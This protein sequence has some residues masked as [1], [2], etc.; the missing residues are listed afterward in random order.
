MTRCVLQEN[1]KNFPRLGWRFIKTGGGGANAVLQSLHPS[2]FPP[3]RSTSK[4]YGLKT[5]AR[6]GRN[7]SGGRMCLQRQKVVMCGLDQTC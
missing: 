6:N 3:F 2:F 4:S 7:V 5:E 1:V